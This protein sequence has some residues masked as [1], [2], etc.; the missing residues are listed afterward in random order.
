MGVVLRTLGSAT[1]SPFVATAANTDYVS[2]YDPY[3][4]YFDTT[5]TEPP[6]TGKIGDTISRPILFTYLQIYSSAG[7]AGTIDLEI[8]PN[9]DASGGTQS[10]GFPITTANND[11]NTNDA[12]GGI[13]YAAFA[14]DP[15]LASPYTRRYYYGFQKNDS[16]TFTFRRGAGN[17]SS[18]NPNGMWQDGSSI[19]S[20]SPAWNTTVINAR[21]RF[22]T[23][24]S[25]PQSLTSTSQTS[26]SIT[27]SWSAPEDDGASNMAIGASSITP[28]H[29]V[30][31]YRILTST[32][33][34]NWFVYG[35]GTSGSPSGT[36]DLAFGSGAPTPPTTVTV[37]SHNGSPLLPGTTYYFKV[38]ALNAVTD[39]HGSA[40]VS[41]IANRTFANYTSTAAHTGTNADSGAIKTLATPKVYDGSS[42]VYSTPK[43]WNG[44]SWISDSVATPVRVKVWDGD[45]WEPLK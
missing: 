43:V 23:V 14:K 19:T 20:G 12:S 44:S 11:W 32:D 21:V 16:N 10:S 42:M 3:D 33:N 27:L 8:S 5:G 2:A 17:S 15:L 39:R 1:Y 28:S 24:S 37:T 26:S 36:H 30:Y 35:T 45:S 41:P 6:L 18:Y 22:S 13:Q 25:A 4:D 7:S 29:A 38:A 9:V 40:V 31:G 34:T